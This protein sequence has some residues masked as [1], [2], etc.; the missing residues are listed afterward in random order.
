MICPQSH[1]DGALSSSL[2]KL[3]YSSR[4][5]AAP[6]T[7]HVKLGQNC[8]QLVEGV[9]RY[10]GEGPLTCSTPSPCEEYHK[11]SSE[12]HLQSD[13]AGLRKMAAVWLGG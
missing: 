5:Q 8:M 9:A 13:T 3:V 4:P 10:S 1:I 2:P 12:E 11:H 7:G 6:P